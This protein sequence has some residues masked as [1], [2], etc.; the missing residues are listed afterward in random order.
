MDSNANGAKLSGFGMQ[1]LKGK[2]KINY[3]LFSSYSANFST[4]PESLT[5]TIRPLGID[6]NPDNFVCA[7]ILHTRNQQIGCLLRLEPNRQAGVR[8]YKTHAT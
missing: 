2:S 3:S 8:K 5:N 4:K 7:A 1:L 6:P